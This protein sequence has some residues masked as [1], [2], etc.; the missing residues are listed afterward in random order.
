MVGGSVC[1][2]CQGHGRWR[3]RWRR[4]WWGTRSTGDQALNDRHRDPQIHTPANGAAADRQAWQTS[5]VGARAA[6]SRQAVPDVRISVLGNAAAEDWL[7]PTFTGRCIHPRWEAPGGGED[8]VL[9]CPALQVQA[10]GRHGPTGHP[11]I[12][13]RTRFHVERTAATKNHGVEPGPP[14]PPCNPK[15]S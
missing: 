9:P 4:G 7:G 2:I 14:H 13:G 6:T 3:G 5:R 10:T 12:R 8:V 15:L 11:S 1:W